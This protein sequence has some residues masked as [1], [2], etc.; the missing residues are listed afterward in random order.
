MSLHTKVVLLGHLIDVVRTV[1]YWLPF[2]LAAVVGLMW[3]SRAPQE[4]TA[5]E[6][7]E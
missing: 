2:A 7:G 6:E 4:T 5:T 3:L 1:P